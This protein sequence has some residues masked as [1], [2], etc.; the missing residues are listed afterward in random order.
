MFLLVKQCNDELWPVVFCRD[1]P[2]L[3]RKR[4]LIEEFATYAT[5]SCTLIEASCDKW[6]EQEVIQLDFRCMGKDTKAC[7]GCTI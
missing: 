3:I 5:C 1:I 7:A 2:A 4:T 6:S